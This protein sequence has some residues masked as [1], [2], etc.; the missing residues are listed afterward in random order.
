MQSS[1]YLDED[2]SGYWRKLLKAD[3]PI[4]EGFIRRTDSPL[5][6][7]RPRFNSFIERIARHIAPLSYIGSED[8][9][10]PPFILASNHSSILDFPAVLFSLPG[11]LREK[12]V[13]IY[14][15]A[16]DRNPFTKFF[17]KLFT[18]S[19]PV[20]MDKKPWEALS[21][22]A[23]VLR[24]GDCIY[25]APEGTRSRT[26]EM[27]PFKPGVGALAVETRSP[28][29]PVLIEGADKVLPRGSLFPKKNRIKVLFGKSIDTLAFF[30]SKRSRPAYD[31]Y[32]DVAE[33]IREKILELKK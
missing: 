2:T 5:K 21:A 11:T 15:S 20:D 18:K 23:K 19:L 22:A 31:V 33:L 26:G 8:L 32:K 1:G 28:I 16:Y 9:P 7:L 10:P 30:E 12:T 3:D 25:I 29:V 14:K 13:A 27:L 24:S 17:I 6:I 4:P